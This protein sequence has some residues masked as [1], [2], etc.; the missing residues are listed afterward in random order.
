MKR[1]PDEKTIYAS[2]QNADEMERAFDALLEAGVSIDDISLLMSEETR[3]RY[4][5]PLIHR[6]TKDGAAAGTAFG[7]TLGGIL[8]GL[9][10]L[11]AALGATTG[12]LVMGPVLAF[13]IAGGAIG[14]LLGWET[15]T[16][17]TAELARDLASGH[18]VIAVHSHR[19]WVIRAAKR[20][21]NRHHGEPVE[22][23]P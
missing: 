13:A 19:P 16:G 11:G 4:F 14:A 22:A 15:P 9:E 6:R 23:R 1:H 10:V 5:K 7:L 21:L 12:I 20:V 8:G 17:S 3:D 18:A 2:F